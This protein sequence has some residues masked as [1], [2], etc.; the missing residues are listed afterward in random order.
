VVGE[1]TDDLV[2]PGNEEYVC[3]RPMQLFGGAMRQCTMPSMSTN[4]TLYL[5]DQADLPR[6]PR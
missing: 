4:L 1:E 6:Y 2:V 5:W 3:A